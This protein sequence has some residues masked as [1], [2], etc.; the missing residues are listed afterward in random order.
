[1]ST[2]EVFKNAWVK[3]LEENERFFIISGQAIEYIGRV[4]AYLYELQTAYCDACE[5]HG[6]DKDMIANFALTKKEE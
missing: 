1:M 4:K 3:H 5:K 6:I 2:E